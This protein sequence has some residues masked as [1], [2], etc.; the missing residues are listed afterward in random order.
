MSGIPGE[1]WR[2]RRRD[3]GRALADLVVTEGDFPW[4]YARVEAAEALGELR[5]LFAEE[6]RLLERIE[7]DADAWERAYEA[8]AAAVVL[9]SPAGV[10]VPEFLIHVDGLEAW[11]RWSD[12]PFD[13]GDS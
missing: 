11:W 3:D 13:G 7:D 1:V 4:L 6:V 12:E 5:P 9:R 2:L 10:D 8:V